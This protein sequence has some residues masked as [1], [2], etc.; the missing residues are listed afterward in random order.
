[1]VCPVHHNCR[2]FR[3]AHQAQTSSHGALEVVG[4]LGLWLRSAPQYPDR[5]HHIAWAKPSADEILAYLRE[6]GLMGPP[7]PLG[8]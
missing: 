2:K 6:Q 1:M 4:F 7:A 5:A 3:S 8:G